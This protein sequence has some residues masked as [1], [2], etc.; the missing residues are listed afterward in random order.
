MNELANVVVFYDANGSFASR[1][2]HELD[3]HPTYF[4]FFDLKRRS[5]AVGT[6]RHVPPPLGIGE[7]KG[8][9]LARPVQ[10]L[11]KLSNI[12]RDP[13]RFIA[14]Q[15][16]HRHLPLRLILEIDLGE[17]LPGSV[18][19]DEGFRKL[20]DRPGRREAARSRYF[21]PSSLSARWVRLRS[22]R[23]S[24]IAPKI[25]F[26]TFSIVRSS[27][28]WITLRANSRVRTSIAR[29]HRCL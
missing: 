14:R 13:P 20:V 17:R 8:R 1:A 4:N 10:Q 9:R 23:Y 3:L 26:L 18:L 6:V 2:L 12:C 24:A 16:L 25:S 7:Y 15:P 21:G 5:V 29:S 27:R 22:L 11:G 19:H 28:R